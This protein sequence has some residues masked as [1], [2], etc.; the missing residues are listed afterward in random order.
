MTRSLSLSLFGLLVLATACR[1]G[2]GREPPIVVIRNM[3]T[4]DKYVHQGHSNFFADGRQMRVPPEG[5]VAREMEV[6]PM[7]SKG[8]NEDDSDWV[9]SIPT[10]V[11]ERQGGMDGMVHRGQE[12]YDIYC[13]PCHGRTGDGRGIIVARGFTAPP[14]YHQDRL[15]HMPDGQVFATI[16]NGVRT[17]PGYYAQIPV[18]DRWAI[19]AYVRALQVS[20]ASRP[21]EP[22]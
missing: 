18:D 11:V 5:T 4:Q 7:I 14:T 9:P 3:Y 15:R 20:Q 2:T 8:R 19:V 21:Q 1:G 22:Q 6:D 16:T 10:E 13:A 17:M 12:R